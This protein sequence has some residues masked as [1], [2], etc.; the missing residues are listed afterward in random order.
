MYKGYR[1]QL[2]TVCK[3]HNTLNR[4]AP[5]LKVFITGAFAY[6][7]LFCLFQKLVFH[8]AHSHIAFVSSLSLTFSQF[9]ELFSLLGELLLEYVVSELAA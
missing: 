4:K 8:L 5:V 6:I 3:L 7:F 9:K 2:K 1:T